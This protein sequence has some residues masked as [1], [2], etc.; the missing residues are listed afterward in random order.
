[1]PVLVS[2]CA[3]V[4]A[5]MHVTLEWPEDNIRTNKAISKCRVCFKVLPMVHHRL[6]QVC[7][8]QYLLFVFDFVAL[9]KGLD[10]GGHGLLHLLH[11]LQTSAMI[12]KQ[13]S[14]PT[15]MSQSHLEFQSLEFVRYVGLSLCTHLLPSPLL[16]TTDLLADVHF[17]VGLS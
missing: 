9:R 7:H 13:C 1:M 2:E 17:C 15:I 4:N 3:S 16:D 11:T 12:N 5:P 8:R 10:V 6:T 14:R